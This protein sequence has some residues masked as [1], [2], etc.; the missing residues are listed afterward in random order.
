MATQMKTPEAVAR[1]DAVASR[2]PSNAKRLVQAAALA[3]VL[4]PLGTVAIEGSVI[5]C[6]TNS[7]GSCAGSFSPGNTSNT[8]KFFDGSELLYSFTL[9]GG[10]S[11]SFSLGVD[12]FIETQASLVGSGRMVNFQNAVCVPTRDPGLCGLF[13]VNGANAFTGGIYDLEISWFSNADPLSVPANAFVLQ[14]KNGF[15]GVF[16]NQLTNGFYDPNPTPD[17]PVV[18]GRGDAFSDFG[19]FTENPIPEPASL[20][21]LASGLGAIVYKRAR[22][23]RAS[24]EDTPP[25]A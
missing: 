8:W 23:R 15:G 2:K 21:L 4:V 12:D 24:P 19:A 1:P 11:S 22:R 9:S 14:A 10:V 6:D 13:S 3:A 16:T 20:L 5:Y 17:D 25:V 18:G 7:S